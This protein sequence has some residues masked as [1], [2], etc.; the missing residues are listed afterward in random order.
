MVRHAVTYLR[1]AFAHVEAYSSSE[2]LFL[3]MDEVWTLDTAAVVANLDEVGHLD[4]ESIEMKGRRYEYA[5]GFD[6]LKDIV[7]NAEHQTPDLKLEQLLEAFLYYYDH[8]AFV[9]LGRTQTTD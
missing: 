4:S 9:D 7:A 1:E 8:D 5:L 2:S 6:T 3:P